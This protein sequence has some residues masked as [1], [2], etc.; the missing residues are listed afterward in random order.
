[1]KLQ[2]ERVVAT[3]TAALDSGI[4]ETALKTFNG[5]VYLYRVTGFGG[6]FASWRLSEG[7]GP[8]LIDQQLFG[9][10]ITYQIDRDGMPVTLGGS[11]QLI[12]DVNTATGLVG[13]GLNSDG[14]IGALQETGT[15]VGGGDISALAQ[16]SITRGDILLLAHEDTGQI[17]TYDIDPDG[18]LSSVGFVSAQVDSMQVVQSGGN[19]F[20]IGTDAASSTVALYS[21]IQTSG[22]INQIDTSYAIDVLGIGTP[23]AVE[24]IE[25]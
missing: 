15:L 25:A 3:G 17:G 16:L 10:T 19:P 4:G 12:L 5:D 6:G 18:S 8:T 13:Y 11:D 7:T 14:T 22:T 20:L 9:P 1:M 21:V 2:F 24:T 23:T